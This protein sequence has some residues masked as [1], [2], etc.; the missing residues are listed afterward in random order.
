M[1]SNERLVRAMYPDSVAIQFGCIYQIR[2]RHSHTGYRITDYLGGASTT[3]SQA[4][5]YAWMRIQQ[6]MLKKLET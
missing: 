3:K 4:W 1:T 5:K 2:I 6:K